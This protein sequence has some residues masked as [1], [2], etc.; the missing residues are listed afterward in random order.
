MSNTGTA[1]RAFVQVVAE[2]LIAQAA[3]LGL[4]VT[5]ERQPL[6][7]LRM[8]HHAPVITIWDARTDSAAT[9]IEAAPPADADARLNAVAMAWNTV[10]AEAR[11]IAPGRGIGDLLVAVEQFAERS[12][13]ALVSESA[14]AVLA[15]R[16]RQIELGYNATED[17]QNEDGQLARAGLC[18]VMTT[19]D[20][21][22]SRAWTLWPWT[23]T[24]WK[25]SDDARRNLIK[26]LAL[27]LADL[28]RRDR[29]AAHKES[30]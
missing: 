23:S 16:R 17:D 28:E 20:M 30:P 13:D 19:L 18:Y 27:I 7:P 14:R 2:G 29:A 15:E 6:Q 3:H 1:D 26:G 22:I 21:S 8:G 5:I 10:R 9:A 24:Q 11:A 12:F 4:V 25:P